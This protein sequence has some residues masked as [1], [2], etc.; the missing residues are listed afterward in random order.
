MDLFF[1]QLS[2]HACRTYLVGPL[3]RGPCPHVYRRRS[4]LARTTLAF[5]KTLTNHLGAIHYFICDDTLTRSAALPGEHYAV[6]SGL[7]RRLGLHEQENQ[8]Q[9]SRD[10][11]PVVIAILA[12]GRHEE[13]RQPIRHS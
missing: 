9:A 11:H 6:W 7:V 3:I 10:R 12:G 13:V 4:R 2:P 5:S 1:R 8:A